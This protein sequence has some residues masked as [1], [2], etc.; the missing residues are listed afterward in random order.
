MLIANGIDAVGLSSAGERPLPVADDQPD[1]LSAATLGDLGRAALCWWPRLDAAAAP[2][3]HGPAAYV[4]L[5]GSLVPGWALALL[6]LTLVLP[7]ALASLDGL[8]RRLAAP[9]AGRLGAGLVGLPGAAARSPPCCSS[10]CSAVTGIVAGPTFPFDPSR[11]GIG[12]GQIVVMALLWR[13]VTSAGYYAIRGWRVPA[14]LPSEAAA[15]ALGLISALAVLVAWLANPFLALLLVPVAHV[16]LLDARRGGALPLAAVARRRR[17]LARSR[18]PP[19]WSTSPEVLDL[20]RGAPWQLLLMVG[21]G[22]IGFG[23]MLALCLLVG[24]PGG[25]HRAGAAAGAGPP[26]GAARRPGLGRLARGAGSRARAPRARRRSGRI[27]YRAT[28]RG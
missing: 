3:E 6:A 15:P 7:A 27:S 26:R 28:R 2:P 14:G 1:D 9:G 13:I 17:R 12:A 8:R 21:D 10:T 4:S 11:F 18:S 5:R 25:T 16:W 20:G 24:Y 19:P 22:Q 23:S